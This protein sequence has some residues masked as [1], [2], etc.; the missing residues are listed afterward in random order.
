VPPLEA[1]DWGRPRPKLSCSAIQEEK[2]D[3]NHCFG[4]TCC[5]NLQGTAA[6]ETAGDTYL[7]VYKT[8]PKR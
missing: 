6:S 2:E 4:E 3:M 7:P 5:L 8:H 1:E